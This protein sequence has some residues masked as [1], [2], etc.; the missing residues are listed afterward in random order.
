MLAFGALI[1]LS[2]APLDPDL[3]TRLRRSLP[4]IPGRVSIA[5][6]GEATTAHLADARSVPFDAELPLQADGLLVAGAMRLDARDALVAALASASPA[7]WADASDARL[8]ARAYR[9]WGDRFAEQLLGD[10]AIVVWDRAQ[11]RLV[12]ARDPH[13]NRQ[14]FWGCVGSVIAVGSSVEVVRSLRGL[15]SGLF[16]PAIRGFL[17]HGWVEEAERTVFRDVRRVPAAHSLVIEGV[18]APVLRRHWDFPVPSPIRYRQQDDY[19]AHFTEVL[20]ACVRDRMRTSS[21]AILLSGGMDS[22]MLAVAAR[23]V[24]PGVPL[25]AFTLTYPTLA[26]SDDDT[27]SVKVATRLGLSHTVLDVDH[28]R[29][30]SYLG[31][32]TALPSQPLDEAELAISR[33]SLATVAAAAPV[34]LYGEDGDWL[35]Q[36]P[37]LLA[38][39]R[40]QPIAEV[41]ASWGS[42]WWSTGRRPWVGL[43]WRSRLSG[44]MGSAPVARTP[45][46]RADGASIASA[47]R[48]SPEHPLR[49]RTVRALSAP[50]W[51]A[52]Y[53]A[54]SPTTTLAPVL[55]TLPLVDPR[56]LAFVFAIP[57]VPWCQD[58]HLFRAAMRGALP[59]AV[60]ARPK[61][62]LGGFT[63]ARVAQWRAGGGADAVISNRVAPWVDA[64]AVRRVLREGTPNEVCD[65]WRVLQVDRWLEREEMRRA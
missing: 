32:L 13:G 14:L 31:D 18:S 8:V 7:S 52:L 28:T 39:L 36:A 48:R 25:S 15:S 47:P 6:S 49:P 33:E 16:D 51:D 65:A 59:S 26:P 46:M 61:T 53:E 45:W 37:T 22:T 42:Y 5:G 35:M 62:P 60:V 58:K 24:A 64:A 2:L 1:D 54:L 17:E 30:L 23:R 27:L 40:S 34:V 12:C 19:V 50:I 43:E 55:H 38:Q 21:A 9:Q 57:P 11:R 56:L 63:E 4:A 44:W 29:A 41:A 20:H 10:Y 3:T